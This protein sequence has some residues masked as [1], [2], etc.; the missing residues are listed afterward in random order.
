MINRAAEENEL[1]LTLREFENAQL[2]EHIT[3]A[4][5]NIKAMNTSDAPL[6]VTPASD[7]TA[8][9]DGDTLKLTLAPYS[10]NVVRIS[11]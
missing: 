10:W 7:T 5:D 4:S 11:V 8:K 3:M 9:F 6:T 1:T 2:I